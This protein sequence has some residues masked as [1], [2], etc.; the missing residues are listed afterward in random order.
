V[1]VDHKADAEGDVKV[2]YV[3]GDHGLCGNAEWYTCLYRMACVKCPF[4]IPHDQAAVI[5]SRDTVETFLKK[6]QLTPE[7]VAAVE[8]D[9][10]KM[11]ETHERTRGV[12]FPHTLHQRAKGAAT[13]GIPLTMIQSERI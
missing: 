11:T 1:L 6:V 12:P 10:D 8:D 13:R 4:F 9:R 7:E 5:H 3:L 2:Y